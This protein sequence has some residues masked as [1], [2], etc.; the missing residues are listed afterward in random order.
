M[1]AIGPM[2]GSTPISVPSAAAASAKNRV[3]GVSATPNPIARLLS[4]SIDHP[5]PFRPDRDRETEPEN[6]DAPGEHDQHHR[7]R[8]RLDRTQFAGGDR[9][10]GDQQQ[11]RDH[12]AEALDGEP[13]DHQAGGDENDRPPGRTGAEGNA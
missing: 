1:V 8:E 7:G 3:A 13:E 2:P 11:D 12:E 9:A 5:L 6:E 10:H 4:S